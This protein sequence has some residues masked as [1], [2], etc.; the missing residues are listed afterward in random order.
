MVAKREKVV[1]VLLAL[2]AGWL[3]AHKFYL[4]EIGWGILY[5]SLFWTGIPAFIAF[6][7]AIGLLLMS[8]E[9]FNLK[10]N[11]T[12]YFVSS[13][14]LNYSTELPSPGATKTKEK[15]EVAILRICRNRRGATV[16]DCVIETGEDPAK[17]KKII[18]DLY[19]QGLLQIGNREADGAIIYWTV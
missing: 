4:G 12:R 6:F 18:D 16:S 15:L 3:G 2:L 7:E 19:K 8:E 9:R 10:F 13:R 14:N 5:A 1:A 17:V 11:Y